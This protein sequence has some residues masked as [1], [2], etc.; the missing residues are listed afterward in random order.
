MTPLQNAALGLCEG[1]IAIALSILKLPTLKYDWWQRRDHRLKLAVQLAVVLL[2]TSLAAVAAE[3]V[4]YE[5]ALASVDKRLCDDVMFRAAH[6][7]M[8]NNLTEPS[9]LAQRFLHD[10]RDISPCNA[11]NSRSWQEAFQ[12]SEPRLIQQLKTW[13]TASPNIVFARRASENV[14]IEILSEQPSAP[15][16]WTYHWLEHVATPDGKQLRSEHCRGVVRVEPVKEAMGGWQL[17]VIA[18]HLDSA[19]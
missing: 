14:T 7:N 18:F 2:G 10:I 15:D 4:G 6:P 9:G 17:R 13:R 19:E 12:Y 16:T 11:C 8:P 5:V 3:G 1:L